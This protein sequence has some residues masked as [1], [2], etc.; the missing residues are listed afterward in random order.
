MKRYLYII[1]I[2]AAAVSIAGCEMMKAEKEEEKKRGPV[3]A[4]IGDEVITLDEFDAKVSRMPDNIKPMIEQNKAAYLDNLVVETLLYKEALKRG[5]DKDKEAK[6][7]FEEAKKRIVMARL[8]KEEVEDLITIDEEDV[9]AYY[10]ERKDE[11]TSPELYRA[12]H[13]LVETMDEAVDIADKLNAGAIFEELA[14][15]HSL[16]ATNKRGG[17]IGYFSPGQMVPEFED[18]CL[19]LEV[20]AVSGP[21]KTQFGY[22]IIKLTDKKTSQPVEFESIRERIES[23]L[24]MEK[25]QALLEVLISRLKSETDIVLNTEFLEIEQEETKGPAAT[26]PGPEGAMPEARDI[27]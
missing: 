9:M 22:H 10:N 12:S 8:I 1:V 6:E 13:I 7:V 23:M 19:K 14:K 26:E 27:F 5:Y 11:F 16:D 15:E 4:R 24:K 2:F 25:R 18:V 17:D 3:L 21:V 20:G